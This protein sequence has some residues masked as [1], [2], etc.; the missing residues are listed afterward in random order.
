MFNK[1]KV[2]PSEPTVRS[3]LG[4]VTMVYALDNPIL[5]LFK[6][7]IVKFFEVFQLKKYKCEETKDIPS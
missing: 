4:E 1:F 5:D 2:R 7:E 6:A 3:S